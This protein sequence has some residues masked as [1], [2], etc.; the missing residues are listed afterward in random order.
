MTEKIS[1]A[2]L[3]AM[4]KAER[5]RDS[6][7]GARSVV[8]DGM[9][10]D[11][12]KELNRWFALV[13]MQRVGLIR[14]LRRQVPIVLFGRDGPLKTDSGKRDRTYVADFVYFDCESGSEVVEDSKG[15]P[16]PEYKLKRAILA[17]Q[18]IEV[19]ET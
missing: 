2:D 7:Y 5:S 19:L 6:K 11:S 10:F 3:V 12:Q 18:G 16:T 9:R 8:Y 4:Q 15:M 13:Q 1:A 14:D 17:A